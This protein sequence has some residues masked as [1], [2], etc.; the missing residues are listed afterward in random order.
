MSAN[1]KTLRAALAGVLTTEVTS[2]Q[3]VYAYQKARLNGQ[4]PVI[5]VTSAGS[6]RERMTMRGG[7]LSALLDIHVFVLYS[8]GASW[9]EAQAEDRLDDIEQQI[10][11]AVEKYARST[12]WASLA[13]AERS[14]ARTP[15]TLEGITYLHEVIPVEIQEHM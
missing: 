13:Y 12:S 14:D 8:D 1:R 15:V 7:R 3:A 6:S 4:T 9:T 2:A 11:A 10:A 5:C